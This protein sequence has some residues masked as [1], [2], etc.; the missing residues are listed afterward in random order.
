MNQHQSV[1]FASMA[2][3]AQY[4]WSE[5]QAYRKLKENHLIDDNQ[6]TL[7]KN[8]CRELGKMCL[9]AQVEVYNKMMTS[10]EAMR[11]AE[12][13]KVAQE[14]A[15]APADLREGVAAVAVEPVAEE[16]A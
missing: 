14:K 7:S 13:A 4:V 3:S 9:N 10:I 1:N 11:A 16:K 2:P 5:F 12:A 6:Y 8:V 15:P